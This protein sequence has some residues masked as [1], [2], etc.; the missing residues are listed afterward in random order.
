MHFFKWLEQRGPKPLKWTILVETAREN[1]ETCISATSGITMKSQANLEYLQGPRT[2]QATLH[3]RINYLISFP[4]NMH[5]LCWH[6]K[7][8]STYLMIISIDLNSLQLRDPK[9]NFLVCLIICRFWIY[10]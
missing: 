9:S 3:W 2:L 5:I 1:N 10:F 4:Q 7:I 8:S 6:N